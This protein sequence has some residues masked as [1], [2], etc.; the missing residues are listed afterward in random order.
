LP[1]CY[2]RASRPRKLRA[3][4]RRGLR[5]SWALSTHP[6][7][8]L[9][10]GLAQLSCRLSLYWPHQRQP[11]GVAPRRARSFQIEVE[12]RFCPVHKARGR[13]RAQRAGAGHWALAHRH[14]ARCLRPGS[15]RSSRAGHGPNR[16][17]HLASNSCYRDN[18]HCHGR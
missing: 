6:Q 5:S 12:Q 16:P 1:V 15:T 18:E 10:G 3:S 9:L 7:Q 2:S 11:P 17:A 14:R 8:L 4:C 13:L